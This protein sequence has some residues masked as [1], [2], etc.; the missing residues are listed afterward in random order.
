MTNGDFHV[1]GFEGLDEEAAMA[2]LLELHQWCEHELGS[3][4]S[5]SR[6]GIIFFNNHV[7]AQAPRN[8]L[9]LDSLIRKKVGRSG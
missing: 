8:A 5:R 3:L 6:R 1:A 2:L 7:R 9:L 4:S